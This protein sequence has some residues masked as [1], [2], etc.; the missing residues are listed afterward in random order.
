MRGAEAK[1]WVTAM[2][3][4]GRTDGFFAAF[5]ADTHTQRGH[6]TCLG[7]P[8]GEW[9]ELGPWRVQAPALLGGTWIGLSQDRGPPGLWTLCG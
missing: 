4:M 8:L 6:A 1:V 9:P 2:Y 3:F 7:H 5:S